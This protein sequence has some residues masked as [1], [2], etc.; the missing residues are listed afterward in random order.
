[1]TTLYKSVRLSNVIHTTQNPN[2]NQTG[3]FCFDV[4]KTLKVKG[5]P[6]KI[7]DTKVKLCAEDGNKVAS[8]RESIEKFFFKF[9]PDLK[10]VN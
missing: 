1:M 6:E 10:N 4:V 9:Y 3:I 2:W 5:K 8:W 7:L